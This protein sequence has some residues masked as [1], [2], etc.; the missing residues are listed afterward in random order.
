MNRRDGIS[1]EGH[2]GGAAIGLAITA[3]LAPRGL[4]PL[5]QWFARWW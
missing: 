1:H 2:L 5:Q 3:L 4:E